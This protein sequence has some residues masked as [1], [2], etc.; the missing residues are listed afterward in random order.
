MRLVHVWPPYGRRNKGSEA[1]VLPTFLK[2]ASEMQGTL[3]PLYSIFTLALSCQ[4][5]QLT[6]S[7]TSLVTN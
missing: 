3:L 7:L 6:L 2:R 5:T 4:G 1:R